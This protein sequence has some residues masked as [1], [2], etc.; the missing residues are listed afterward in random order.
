MI[1][2]YEEIEQG[3]HAAAPHA[4]PCPFRLTEQVQTVSLIARVLCP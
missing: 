4:G 1:K 2:N 3:P